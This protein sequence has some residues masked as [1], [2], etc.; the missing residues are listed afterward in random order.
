MKS[1]KLKMLDV[2]R[3]RFGT[4][5]VVSKVSGGQAALAFANERTTQKIAWYR[6]EELTVIGNVT[7]MVK[8]SV[9]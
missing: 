6:P 3:T 8:E 4:I 9:E 7:N 5:A 2:V 1:Q